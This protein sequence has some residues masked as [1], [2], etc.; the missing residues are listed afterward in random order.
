MRG[1]AVL[2]LHEKGKWEYF[3]HGIAPISYNWNCTD[4][5]VLQLDLPTEQ[6]LSTSHGLGGRNL[7]Q[8]RK[9][10]HHGET[11]TAKTFY[12]SFNS[13]AIYATAG[14]EGEADL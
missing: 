9:D 14:Q 2:K 1:I 5:R 6:G 12:A 11:K 8:R 7:V 10:I 3:H 4:H 13:S